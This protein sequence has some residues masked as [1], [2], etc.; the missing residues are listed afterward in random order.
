MRAV[1]R[2][3]LFLVPNF[4]GGVGGA[5]RV[6]S[7]LLRHI[8]NT[9]FECHLATGHAGGELFN[10]VP[11]HVPIHQLNVSRMRYSL[12]GIIRLIW[13]VRPH[14]VLATVGY[15]NVMLILARPFL[16][17][18]IR[19]LL[20]EAT[21]PSAFVSQ[22]TPHPK[23]WTWFYRHLYRRAEKVVCLSDS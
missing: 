7:S 20:R 6:I 19:L 10:D 2:R 11:E 23:L 15:L 5:E 4:T 21:T 12:P 13:A 16:P 8:D 14:T 3:V 22:D 17:R 1:R 18:D 9:K